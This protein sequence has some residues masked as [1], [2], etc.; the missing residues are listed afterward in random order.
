M[1]MNPMKAGLTIAVVIIA[2]IAIWPLSRTTAREAVLLFL[3][4]LVILEAHAKE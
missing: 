4:F 2:I 1:A 3:L